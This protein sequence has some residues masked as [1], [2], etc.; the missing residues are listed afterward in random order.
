MTLTRRYARALSLLLVLACAGPWIMA[1]ESGAGRGPESPSRERPRAGHHH[2]DEND[3][4]T[5]RHPF[6]G[7]DRWAR[8]FDDP[9]RDKWQKPREVVAALKLEPGMTVADIGAGTG[10][11]NRHLAEAVGPGGTVLALDAEPGMVEHMKD[12]AVEE[13]TPNVRA[14]LVEPSD[15]R[16]PERGVDLALIVDT[17]HH[18][19]DRLRYFERV[20]RAL[21][22]GGR[23][24][25]IDFLKKP[26]PVGPR[27]D[28]KIPREHVVGELE[29]VGFRL[30]EEPDLL[31]YQYFLIFSLE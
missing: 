23:L 6:D 29:T 12:R 2:G 18:I 24:A 15:P 5:S 21:K 4:A 20:K 30:V 25:V 3:D 7:A 22:P 16:L 19:D 31:P 11:F 28:H 10:Y 8:V 1:E 27:P 26:I 17:Y 13:S 9:G 14:V